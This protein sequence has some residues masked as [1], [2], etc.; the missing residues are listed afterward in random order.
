M[1]GNL[2][3]LPIFLCSLSSF[4]QILNI[5]KADTSAYTR[6]TKFSMALNSG[7]EIDKQKI[8]LYD[9]TNTLESMLQHSKELFIFAASH[10]FT[11]NGADDI[12][13]AGYVHLRYRHGYKN[14]LQPEPFIQY[15]FDNKRGLLHRFLSGMNL[16]YNFWRGD[17]FDLNAGLGLMYEDEKWNYAAVDSSKIPPDPVAIR[18]QSAKINSY[19]RFDWKTSANSTIAFN[20]FLQTKPDEFRPRIAPHVQWDIDAG[21]HFGFSIAFSGIYDTKPVVPIAKFYY[22]LSYTLFVKF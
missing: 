17:V 3:L 6:K 11:Y 5:D 21:K 10:R 8:T 13:N 15:Q 9:A 1:K 19:L 2:L 22:S 4:G 16:R 7:L 20:I 14:K 12:L 18:K